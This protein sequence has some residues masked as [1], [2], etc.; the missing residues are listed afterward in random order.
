MNCQGYRPYANTK[1]GTDRVPNYMQPTFPWLY[2]T[3]KGGKKRKAKLLPFSLNQHIWEMQVKYLERSTLTHERDLR[4]EHGRDVQLPVQ[5]WRKT[6]PTSDPMFSSGKLCG[7]M[8]KQK[9]GAHFEG[10][11]E[12]DSGVGRPSF[13]G[14]IKGAKSV[15]LG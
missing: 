14:K 2:N 10:A 12:N 9:T 15:Q 6:I 13:K 5:Q 8:E 3:S 4:L 7:H 1:R 11:I